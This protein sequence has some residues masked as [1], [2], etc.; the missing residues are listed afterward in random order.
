M[1]KTIF[2]ITILL[3]YVLASI[4]QEPTE[5]NKNQ[6]KADVAAKNTDPFSTDYFQSKEN[7]HF[8][9]VVKVID[10]A[11][12]REAPAMELRPGKIQKIYTSGSFKVSWLD[13]EG[14]EIGSYTMED[15]TLIRTWEKPEIKK[16]QEGKVEIKLPKD[17]KISTLVLSS[18]DKIL[19]RW[20][21]D[22][23]IKRL[24]DR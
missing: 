6:N 22:D 20:R 21:I 17:L 12:S 23:Q 7:Q 15:P 10:G 3:V 8:V 9:A 5:E 13:A 4:A 14:E 19:Q 1:K 16:L 2:T 24:T 11:I 18:E